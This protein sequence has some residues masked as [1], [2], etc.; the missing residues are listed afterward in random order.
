MNPQVPRPASPDRPQQQVRLVVGSLSILLV[1][2]NWQLLSWRVLDY[3]P[4]VSEHD[5]D[6]LLVTH[7]M[8]RG[9][10]TAGESADKA[11][12][13]PAAFFHRVDRKTPKR[14]LQWRDLGVADLRPQTKLST[15]AMRNSFGGRMVIFGTHEEGARDG[16]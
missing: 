15:S 12:L 6:L 9:G 10:C 14:K 11:D 2:E 7:E 5:D 4:L 8:Q 16:D 3:F 1:V 13:L